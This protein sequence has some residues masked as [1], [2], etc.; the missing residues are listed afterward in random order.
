MESPTP[1]IRKRPWVS[2]VFI[3]LG[4]ALVVSSAYLVFMFS[5][6]ARQENLEF[7]NHE[8]A[9]EQQRL[10]ADFRQHVE[11]YQDFL[12]AIGFASKSEFYASPAGFEEEVRREMET[13]NVA[14]SPPLPK[15]KL[16][17]RSLVVEALKQKLA[18]DRQ[19]LG[20]T[21]EIEVQKERHES[22]L[23]EAQL[24]AMIYLNQI[25]RLKE[26]IK[27]MEKQ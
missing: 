15:D 14:L 11:N 26:K 16:N 9:S 21:K 3:C 18:L 22:E 25:D 7:R 20:L 2:K 19:V 17:F 23:K 10:E 27:E 8:L 6:A 5:W 1:P 12:E 24:Q 13:V 4:T